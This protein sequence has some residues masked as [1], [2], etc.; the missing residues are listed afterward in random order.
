MSKV[1]SGP[2]GGGLDSLLVSRFVLAYFLMFMRGRLEKPLFLFLIVL[3]CA[4]KL[5]VA[6]PGCVSFPS[7]NAGYHASLETAAGRFALC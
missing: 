3:Y 4:R 2:A 1:K 6:L 7:N 5:L